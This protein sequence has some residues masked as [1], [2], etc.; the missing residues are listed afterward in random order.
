VKEID[1]SETTICKLSMCADF[2]VCEKRKLGVGKACVQ[3]NRKIYVGKKWSGSQFFNVEGRCEW[4][5]ESGVA[6]PQVNVFYFLKI[7]LTPFNKHSQV[8]KRTC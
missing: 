2:A 3:K 4:S 5:V 6:Q 8:H 1:S 7:D